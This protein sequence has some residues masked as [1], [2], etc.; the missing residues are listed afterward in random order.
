MYVL[1]SDGV[2][3]CDNVLVYL[4]NCQDGFLAHLCVCVL[5]GH[6]GCLCIAVVCPE[7]VRMWLYDHASVTRMNLY[8][9]TCTDVCLGG[10]SVCPLR[11][12]WS[13][14]PGTGESKHDLLLKCMC[15]GI[16]A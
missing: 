7:C 16:I 6:F 13:V 9:S 10:I 5:Q 11:S 12:Y 14:S 4:H 8:A 15:V 1:V 2:S 3:L